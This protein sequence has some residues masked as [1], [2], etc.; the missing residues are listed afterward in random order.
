MENDLVRYQQAVQEIKDE[1]IK[2]HHQLKAQNDEEIEKLCIVYTL[3][4]E[5]IQELQDELARLEQENFKMDQE[6]L[7]IYKNEESVENDCE[8]REKIRE[9]EEENR[10]LLRVCDG[11]FFANKLIVADS[12]KKVLNETFVALQKKLGSLETVNAEMEKKIKKTEGDTKNLK[13]KCENAMGRCKNNEDLKEKIKI[14]EAA[15]EKYTFIESA[16]V[17]EIKEAEEKLKIEKSRPENQIDAKTAQKLVNEILETLKQEKQKF[18]ALENE[19][20]NKKN[21]LEEIKNFGTQSNKTTNKLRNELSLL[22][23]L[24]Q[25]KKD[26]VKELE[27]EIENYE[28][29]TKALKVDIND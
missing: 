13:K 26:Q 24:L 16:L 29:K 25:D 11:S 1:I 4:Q 17:T 21:Y 9:I 6:A 22:Q 28:H 15:A 7:E 8:I 20:N 23:S 12:D 3:C 14:L 10:E 18:V 27:K 5:D 2:T 19:L